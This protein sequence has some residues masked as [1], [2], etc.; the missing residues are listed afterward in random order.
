MRSPG[1]TVKAAAP[2]V[3]NRYHQRS[4]IVGID[5]TDQIAENDAVLVAQSRARQ[6]HRGQRG[7]GDVNRNAGG[8]ELGGAGRKDEGCAEAGTQV[9]AGGACGGVLGQGKFLADARIQD[10]QLNRALHGLSARA[11]G[12]HSIARQGGGSAAFACT[13]T[14]TAVRG[15]QTAGNQ[16]NELARNIDFR[17]ARDLDLAAGPDHGERIVLAIKGDAVAHSIRGDHVELLAF[18]LAAGIVFDIVGL[19]RE[20]HDERPL[21]HVRNRFDDVGRRFEIEFDR[22][23]LLLDLVFG[24]GH[25]LKIGDCGRR[26]EHVGIR[27]LAV[28]R[29]V[30]VARAFHIDACDAGGGRELHP[31][32]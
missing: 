7:I 13:A 6:Q 5:Q 15:R 21:G 8:N 31:G 18:E 28:H 29:R 27:H 30:H 1:L 32:R 23:A 17:S 16:G 22:D 11:A 12:A 10:P 2:P 25:G 4:L 14:R 3:P 9:H 26:N 24:D 20:T 19:G